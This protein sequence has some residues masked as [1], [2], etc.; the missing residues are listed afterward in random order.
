MRPDPDRE[1][2]PPSRRVLSF[3]RGLTPYLDADEVTQRCLASLAARIATGGLTE[4]ERGA[5]A[6]VLGGMIDEELE[7]RYR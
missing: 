2:V 6:D 3:A 5:A 7:K 4:D 1:A